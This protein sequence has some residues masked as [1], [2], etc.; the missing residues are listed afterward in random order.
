MV[1]LPSP[2]NFPGGL[3][4]ATATRNSKLNLTTHAIGPGMTIAARKYVSFRIKHRFN[5]YAS[6]VL[7][8]HGL[9][10]L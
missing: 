6:M 10:H 9:T 3:V 7:I 2:K 8:N 4:M 5:I 1:Y